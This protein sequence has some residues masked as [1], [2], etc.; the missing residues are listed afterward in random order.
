MEVVMAVH[1]Y[2]EYLGC[3]CK[4]GIGTITDEAR[5]INSSKNIDMFDHNLWSVIAKFK[6]NQWIFQDDNAPVHQSVQTKLWKNNN[7]VDCLDW[8]SQSPD[9]NIIEN[10]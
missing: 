7:D 5:N 4:D 1:V 6:N 10:I 2:L 8:P 9:L 3:I